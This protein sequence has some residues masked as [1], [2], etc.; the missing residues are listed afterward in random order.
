M[1]K[2]YS[3]YYLLPE[4]STNMIKGCSSYFL[5]VELNTNRIKGIHPI[6]YPQ[7]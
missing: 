1:I 2:V 5:L 3:S 7:S 4:L 6:I